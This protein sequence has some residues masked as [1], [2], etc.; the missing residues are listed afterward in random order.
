[1]L[2]ARDLTKIYKASRFFG[3]VEVPAVAGV[4]LKVLPARTLGVVGESGSGKS[5]LARMMMLLLQATS[6]DVLF[7]GKPSRKFGAADWRAF[8]RSV[9]IVFQ[10]P[11]ASLNP[12]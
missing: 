7:E 6:G 3:S 10:D 1:M 12:R 4:S 2:E 11:V 9:Q 8:R 5:T